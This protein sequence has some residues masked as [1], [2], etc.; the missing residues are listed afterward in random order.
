[1]NFHETGVVPSVAPP[2]LTMLCL[3]GLPALVI[4]LLGAVVPV[5]IVA[6]DY[7]DFLRA[8]TR[9]SRSQSSAGTQLAILY[10]DIP[11]KSRCAIGNLVRAKRA[12]IDPFDMPCTVS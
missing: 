8:I 9:Y 2:S 12:E 11:G 6:A 3:G 5:A 10:D 7:Q 1:M 4:V